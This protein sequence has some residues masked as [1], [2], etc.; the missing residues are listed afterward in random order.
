[1]AMSQ[2]SQSDRNI[3]KTKGIGGSGVGNIWF[4]ADT[5]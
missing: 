2:L 5:H 1:M 3:R 4:T